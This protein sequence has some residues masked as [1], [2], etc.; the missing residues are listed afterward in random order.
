M[1][2]CES[3]FS[4][5]GTARGAYSPYSSVT[6]QTNQSTRNACAQHTSDGN[7]HHSSRDARDDCAVGHTAAADASS[8]VSAV[9]QSGS[10]A[11][12]ASSRMA[13]ARSDDYSDRPHDHGM[14][15]D[16]CSYSAGVS[17]VAPSAA[18]PHLQGASLPISTDQACMGG[19]NRADL[20]RSTSISN[21]PDFRADADA[22]LID[23]A[24][25]A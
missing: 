3:Q 14:H 23:F 10:L 16:Q 15:A 4:R 19:E 18:A 8:D 2:D 13:C 1:A 9:A 20:M 5:G 6:P 12:H 25:D 11:V 7:D 21:L 24:D 17:V 22:P